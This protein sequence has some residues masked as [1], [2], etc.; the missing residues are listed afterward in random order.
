MV[1]ANGTCGGGT[2]RYWF[3]WLVFAVVSISHHYDFSTAY[4]SCSLN[5]TSPAVRQF[6]N[7]HLGR[8]SST[9]ISQSPR[10]CTSPIDEVVLRC[11]L[12]ASPGC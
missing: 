2:S 5:R 10:P 1:A 7:V 4:W 12:K 9:P 6:T 8:L 11:E 3:V